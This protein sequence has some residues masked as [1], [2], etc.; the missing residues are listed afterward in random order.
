VNVSCPHCQHAINF[1]TAKPGRFKP[2]CPKCGKAFVLTIAADGSASA[3]VSTPRPAGPPA[4]DAAGAR[5]APAGP[6][7]T[8]ALGPSRPPATSSP[9]AGGATEVFDPKATPA[10]AAPTKP[11][12][13]KAPP[14]KS[15]PAPA[16]GATEVFDPKAPATKA[17]AAGGA[18]EAFVPK[19]TARKGGAAPAEASAGTATEAFAPAAEA[20]NTAPLGSQAQEQTEPQGEPSAR[21]AP[22][23]PAGAPRSLGGYEVLSELGKGGMGTV[24]LARQIS[25]DRKVALK[26]MNPQW[27]QD[28][29][30]L[31]RFIR[32]AYAAAQLVHHN[33]V[34]IY[35]IGEQGGTHFFSMEFVPGSTLAQMVQR[36]GKLDVAAAVGYTLQAARGLKFAHEQ[37][38]V[39]RDVKPENM[40]VNDHGIVKVA[41]LGL[42]K[43][44]EMTAEQDNTGRPRSEI[45]IRSGS[46]VTD[47][48]QAMGTPAYMAP[49][50]GLNA[51]AVDHRADIYS[52]GCTLYVLLTGRPPF[53]GKTA[54]EVMTKHLQDPVVR[55]EKIEPRVPRELSDILMRMLAKKPEERYP[56]LGA[57]IRDLEQFLGAAG[58]G[59]PAPK[60][61]EAEA[62]EK[63]A[64]AFHA[65]PAA[66]M[67]GMT[68]LAFFGGCVALALLSLL[69]ARW[70]VGIALK[71]SVSFLALGVFTGLAA[72]I[73]SGSWKRGHLYLEARDLVLASG[74]GDR[75][76]W[77]AG[78][79]L[80][81]VVLWLV[82]LLWWW[83][84][85]VAVAAGMAALYHLQVDRRM[86]E[87]RKAALDRAE[88]V[89]KAL[90][91]RGVDE[92]AVRQ[93]VCKYSGDHWEEFFEA[94]FGYPA[95]VQ[96]RQRWSG[97]LGRD[98]PKFAAW[99]EPVLRWI[100][101]RRKARKEARE[102]KHL[103]K[104]ERKALEARGVSAAE[105]K[106][107]AEEAAEDLV[108]QAAKLKEAVLRQAVSFSA[109]TALLTAR[110]VISGAG[111]PARQR[112]RRRPVQRVVR[113]VFAPR[114]RFLAGAALIGLCLLWA[115]QNDLLNL[116]K[117]TRVVE[118]AT[119]GD[120]KH[121]QGYWEQARNAHPLKLP[122]D[123]TLSLFNS[124]NPLIAGLLLV[125]AAFT[126][127]PAVAALCMAGALVVF[128]GGLVPLP[129]GLN[130]LYVWGATGV[131][132]LVLAV[133]LGRF[134]R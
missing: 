105:A 91:L 100:E 134:T 26:T 31:T 60:P 133:I 39:H 119:E 95:M 62:I 22:A 7:V 75:L 59:P 30:F 50:Q 92:E 44:P 53:K 27:A 128:L 41:D 127:R 74:W 6:E 8:E 98:R 21:P 87:Q 68:T 90:R 11:S 79:V 77:L 101:T 29:V 42:V 24:Y 124:F 1:K 88:K 110:S 81:L 94:L 132:V 121:A 86:A 82:G 109:P 38:M 10:K 78:L 126:A 108:E 40:M 116:E 118:G 34:Q 67:R 4:G 32:E 51:A 56:D 18:T 25:L 49:E 55:P 89:L 84:L 54:M 117:I 61:E 66:R 115:E 72:F 47:I 43:T 85:V 123:I 52:L 2:N 107:R 46:E 5:Q 80:A 14:A 130:P 58:S 12:P 93:F 64:K 122:F 13:A 104:L 63:A 35:D 111:R 23:P 37:G 102:R 96:A 16:G 106:A 48:G 45:A 65:A 15:T 103:A 114:T 19:A 125:L 71:L 73:V 76:T 113:A 57:V 120:V 83:L 131:V 97:E 99:R 36:D 3:A 28:P 129:A 20:D 9:A 112:P 70:R 33:V 17:P 69:V